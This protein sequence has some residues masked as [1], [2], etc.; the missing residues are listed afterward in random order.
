MKKQVGAFLIENG[1]LSGPKQYMNEQGS[2]KLEHILAGEDVVF[3]TSLLYSP[4]AATGL[5]V[6]MQTDYAGW[7][8]R[9]ERERC[10]Q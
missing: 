8:G 7:L 5:L 9:K 1:A 6:A 4:D 3:N 10:M 2:A